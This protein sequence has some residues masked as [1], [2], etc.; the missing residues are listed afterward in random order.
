MIF[1]V[2]VHP[3]ASRNKVVKELD[4]YKVYLSKPAQEGLANNQLLELLS[5]YLKVKKY[6]L[7]IIQGVKSRNKLIEVNV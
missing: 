6:Q 5:D 3:R 2:R 4:S 1:K 7:K